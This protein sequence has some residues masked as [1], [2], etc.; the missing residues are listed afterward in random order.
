MPANVREWLASGLQQEGQRSARRWAEC[1]GGGRAPPTLFLRPARVFHTELLVSRLK[2]GDGKGEKHVCCV[3]GGS[4][5]AGLAM[6]PRGRAY[7]CL[8]PLLTRSSMSRMG[9]ARSCSRLFSGDTGRSKH[10]LALRVPT[11]QGTPRMEWLL[12]I[13]QDWDG[14]HLGT[15]WRESLPDGSQGPQG[16]L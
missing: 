15:H 13:G 1:R 14:S 6:R 9:V 7:L 4:H 16:G 3:A 2:N 11:P 10:T 8:F 5:W 12:Q